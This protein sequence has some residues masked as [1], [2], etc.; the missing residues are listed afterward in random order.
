MLVIQGLQE[1]MFKR[2]ALKPFRLRFDFSLRV[3]HGQSVRQRGP[4]GH[5]GCRGEQPAAD[6]QRSFRL[7]STVVAL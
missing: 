5:L 3:D 1:E 2:H 7:N 6:L 4:R